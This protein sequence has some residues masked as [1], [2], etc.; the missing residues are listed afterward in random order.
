MMM[1]MSNSK[2][3]I[4][5]ENLHHL[6][7]EELFLID[8]EESDVQDQTI[9]KLLIISEPLDHSTKA[10][11]GKIIQSIQLTDGDVQVVESWPADYSKYRSVLIF[12]NHSNDEYKALNLYEVQQLGGQQIVRSES[13]T[14]LDKDRN[15]KLKLWGVLKTWYSL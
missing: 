5:R 2:L 1:K 11:L 8:N 9:D 7:H 13:L 12:G 4:S 6:I 3:S 14:E 10:T 15:K